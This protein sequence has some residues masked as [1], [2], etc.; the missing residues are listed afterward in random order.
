M[1]TRMRGARRRRHVVA[2]VL[3][4]DVNR[5]LA[6]ARRQNERNRRA[7]LQCGRHFHPS[8]RAGHRRHGRFGNIVGADAG[9]EVVGRDGHDHF[10]R[11]GHERAVIDDRVGI[12]RRRN[13]DQHR[14]GRHF[15]GE[16]AFDV[17]LKHRRHGIV[18]GRVVGETGMREGIGHAFDLGSALRSSD[19]GEVLKYRLYETAPGTSIQ[20]RNVSVSPAFTR[21]CSEAESSVVPA[22]SASRPC[23]D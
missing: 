9:I 16:L 19:C 1:L 18:I 20:L 21:H 7:E 12:L 14:R 4:P 3:E 10:R 15:F 8:R 2:D 17:P 11:I 23:P 13:V 6:V 22:T 5:L